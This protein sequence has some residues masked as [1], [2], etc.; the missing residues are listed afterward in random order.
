M[1]QN[2]PVVC[3]VSNNNKEGVFNDFFLFWDC[4]A[5]ESPL[6]PGRKARSNT[7]QP[8]QTATVRARAEQARQRQWQL[9]EDKR[10]A[11]AAK[12]PSRT[13]VRM[14]QQ[15]V[16]S[17]DWDAIKKD[18]RRKTLA[19]WTWLSISVLLFR[20]AW[21]T[22]NNKHTAWKRWLI[23]WLECADKGWNYV[24]VRL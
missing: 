15:A 22:Q 2:H 14:K 9:E 20:V 19:W 5:S 21:V 10:K 17:M 11:A 13:H 3:Q 4:L 23:K 1:I 12:V 6:E 24:Q 7:T 18:H 8:G 16:S